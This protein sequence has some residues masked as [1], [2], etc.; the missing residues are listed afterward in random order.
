MPK[1]SKVEKINGDYNR[2]KLTKQYFFSKKNWKN[3]ENHMF[4][5]KK[6]LCITL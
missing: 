4:F 5:S 6:L 1:K 3:L 2:G